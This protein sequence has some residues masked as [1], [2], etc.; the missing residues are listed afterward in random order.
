MIS[1]RLGRSKSY[2]ARRDYW[3]GKKVWQWYFYFWWPMEYNIGPNKCRCLAMT[4]LYYLSSAHST[5]VLTEWRCVGDTTSKKVATPPTMADHGYLLIHVVRL[6]LSY[7][8]HNYEHLQFDNLKNREHWSLAHNWMGDV[9]VM[10]V[11]PHAMLAHAATHT[12]HARFKR[13]S[14]STEVF[15]LKESKNKNLQGEESKN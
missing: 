2:V 9:I 4:S 1:K 15:F 6:L 11:L 10:V 13:T 7:K 12:W 14:K 3:T 5:L 8:S